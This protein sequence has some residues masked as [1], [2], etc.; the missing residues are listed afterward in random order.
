MNQGRID[1]KEEK[2]ITFFV[3]SSTHQGKTDFGGRKSD[4]RVS[5]SKDFL[6]NK[7]VRGAAHR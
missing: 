6:T 3:P 1:L 4:Y 2:Q 5:N 7:K